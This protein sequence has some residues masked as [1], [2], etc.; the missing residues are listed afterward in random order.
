M[1]GTIEELLKKAQDGDIEAL[2][3]VIEYY[4]NDG[5]EEM[6]DF[7]E[8]KLKELLDSETTG[9]VPTEEESKETD[10]KMQSD[11][12]VD[13]TKIEQE[14]ANNNTKGDVF[15]YA[16]LNIVELKEKAEDNDPEA[17]CELA[18]RYYKDNQI[19]KTIDLLNSAIEILK[20]NFENCTE[21]DLEC[22]YCCYNLKSFCY[23]KDTE[24][25]FLA[26]QN[27]AEVPCNEKN[28]GT[29]Y[30]RLALFYITY[31]NDRKAYEK[32]LARAATVS[33]YCCLKV[34]ALYLDEGNNVDYEYWLEKAEK[35]KSNG[36]YEEQALSTIIEFKKKYHNDKLNQNDYVK[37]L[38]DCYDNHISNLF[39]YF[40]K[41]E[42][43]NIV[44]K[45]S[46]IC[47][48]YDENEELKKDNLDLFNI[49]RCLTANE[50]EN[51]DN[52]KNIDFSKIADFQTKFFLSE[53]EKNNIAWHITESLYKTVRVNLIK[54][55]R[56]DVLN[57]IKEKE[58]VKDDPELEKLINSDIEEI[59]LIIKNR[60]EE[61]NRK[62]LEEERQREIQ[63]E[64][65]KFQEEMRRQRE[66]EYIRKQ[67]EDKKIIM[68]I[69]IGCA[70]FFLFICVLYSISFIGDLISAAMDSFS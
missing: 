24:E 36:E 11:S 56:I 26:L 64:E 22:L 62:R 15:S 14:P 29:T 8:G 31:K 17:Y 63:E 57:K 2:K 53:I 12:E 54:N 44:N 51:P 68:Y 37:I 35:M 16:D 66:A 13:G 48:Q 34:A 20:E 42:V 3:E 19:S 60:Q 67:E 30:L 43:E 33:K 4:K 1:E 39:Y 47:S 65:K 23:E 32:Y 59:S 7:F 5:D 27:A 70:A 28:K 6:I 9:Q 46:D 50:Q 58:G 40:S 61:E 45:I 25:R 21:N 49:C 38:L 52:Y 55:E 41:K 18:S 69:I 10:E